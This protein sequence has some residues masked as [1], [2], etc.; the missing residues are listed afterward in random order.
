MKKAFITIISTFG[1]LFII[2]VFIIAIKNNFDTTGIR[3]S[4]KATFQQ[5]TQIETAN[6]EELIKNIEI[7]LKSYD[8][9]Q[10]ASQNNVFLQIA[11]STAWIGT[12]SIIILAGVKYSIGLSE[13]IILIIQF[14]FNPITY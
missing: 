11:S 14:I 8:A 3:F 12:L 5:L 7:A 6:F 9:I 13:L 10:S 1:F 2:W 4:L